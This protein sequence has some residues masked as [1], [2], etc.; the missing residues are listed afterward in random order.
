MVSQ[1]LKPYPVQ[2][3]SQEREKVFSWLSS[4]DFLQNQRDTFTKHNKVLE[5]GF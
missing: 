1:M 3:P 2:E 4:P 5:V